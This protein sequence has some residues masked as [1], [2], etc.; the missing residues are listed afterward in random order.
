MVDKLHSSAIY[1]CYLYT[2]IDV[3]APVVGVFTSVRTPPPP[4][5]NTLPTPTLQLA[6]THPLITR[7]IPSVLHEQSLGH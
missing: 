7:L 4:Q 5:S 6:L 3:S 2:T 1:G